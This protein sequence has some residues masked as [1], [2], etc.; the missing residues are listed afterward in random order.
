MGLF[1]LA[2][3]PWAM[4]KKI[5]F[6]DNFSLL[7][8]HFLMG[9]PAR[10]GLSQAVVAFFNT[11]PLATQIP[12]RMGHLMDALRLSEA[13]QLLS[14]LMDSELKDFWIYWCRHEWNYLAFSILP[15]L[16]FA[17][18][19][20]LLQ[21]YHRKR[22][23]ANALG[24]CESWSEAAGMLAVAL[25]TL[26]AIIFAGYSKHAPDLVYALPMGLTV[27]AQMVLVGVIL[28]GKS[29]WLTN[30][31]YLFVGVNIYRLIYAYAFHIQ[32]QI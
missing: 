3:L 28:N 7:R 5:Y 24:D 17:L 25:L 26:T 16:P 19:Q 20:G 4:V 18:P 15:L 8:E 29:R 13:G 32:R 22:S 2:N 31:F 11:V 23:T 14:L 6:P 30:G 1:V 9:V 10:G 21:C 12:V 27:L